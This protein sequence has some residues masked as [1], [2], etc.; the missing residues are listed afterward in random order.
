MTS[1]GRLWSQRDHAAF[2]SLGSLRCVWEG[3]AMTWILTVGR[4]SHS[5]HGVHTWLSD[6]LEIHR[7]VPKTDTEQCVCTWQLN[8]DGI[9]ADLGETRSSRLLIVR[10]Q[11]NANTCGEIIISS[12]APPWCSWSWSM[13]ATRNGLGIPSLFPLLPA[14]TCSAA[15]LNDL[16]ATCWHLSE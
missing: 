4:K 10:F 6:V 16:Q 2:C 7:D 14:L 13:T 11:I 8:K 1:S 9:C 3:F 12:L 5:R 15:A